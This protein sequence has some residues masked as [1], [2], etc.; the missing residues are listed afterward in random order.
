MQANAD[1]Q[2]EILGINQSMQSLGAFI[3][4]LI[5]GYLITFGA[6]VPIWVGAFLVLLA[7]GMFVVFFRK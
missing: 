2:G 3:P 7:W 5:G 6:S 1:Q 4:P